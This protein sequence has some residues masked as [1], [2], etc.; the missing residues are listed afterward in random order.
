[1]KRI[2]ILLLPAVALATLL[3]GCELSNPAPAPTACLEIARK[4]GA[5]LVLVTEAKVN[6][7]IVFRSCSA[8]DFLVVWPGDVAGNYFAKTFVDPKD[9]PRPDGT[10][11][12]RYGKGLAFNNTVGQTLYKY[13]RPG[14][15]TVVLLATNVGDDL[16]GKQSMTTTELVITE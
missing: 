2:P 9:P 3:A 14:T 1:M 10:P 7:E 12:V 15:Y 8:A 4:E 13:A 16:E 11:N 5:G 6:Q